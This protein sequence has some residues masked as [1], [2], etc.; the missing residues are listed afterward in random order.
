MAGSANLFW[1]MM[2]SLEWGRPLLGYVPSRYYSFV[3][4]PSEC[5]TENEDKTPKIRTPQHLSKSSVRRLPRR[6]PALLT[7]AYLRGRHSLGLFARPRQHTHL[8][9]PGANVSFFR[10]LAI[11]DQHGHDHHYIS[12]GFSN[13]E[14]SKPRH[15]GSPFEIGRASARC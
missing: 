8:G 2:N 11:G 14:Y 13:P 3:W 15:Q 6:I 1:E 4:H 5:R 9:G 7:T 10:Y 12:N